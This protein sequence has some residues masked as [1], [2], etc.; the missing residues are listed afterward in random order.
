MVQK[1]W[2]KGGTKKTMRQSSGSS[3]LWRGRQRERRSFGEICRCAAV[4][5]WP[6]LSLVLLLLCS[7]TDKRMTEGKDTPEARRCLEGCQ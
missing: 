4:E 5:G 2:M 7:H 6:V 1:Q 3:G